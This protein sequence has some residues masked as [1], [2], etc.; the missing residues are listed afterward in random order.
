MHFGSINAILSYSDHRYVSTT[1]V[2]VF[3]VISARIQI[4]L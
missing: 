2:A 1:H 3:R 4:Y